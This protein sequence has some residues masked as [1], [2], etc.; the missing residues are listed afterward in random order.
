MDVYERHLHHIANR[1][2]TD[3]TISLVDTVLTIKGG[4]VCGDEPRHYSVLE[5][6]AAVQVLA[7]A[8]LADADGGWRLLLSARDRLQAGGL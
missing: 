2:G 6:S 1:C 8:A 4:A 5:N 3:W 7:L